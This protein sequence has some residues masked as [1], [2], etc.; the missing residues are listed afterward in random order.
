MQALIKENS[1]EA[2]KYAISAIAKASVY[3]KLYLEDLIYQCSGLSLL[4]AVAILKK[5]KDQLVQST[6]LNILSS[7]KTLVKSQLVYSLANSPNLLVREAA[8]A[9]HANNPQKNSQSVL[10]KA[11]NDENSDIKKEACRGLR[12][13]PSR[14]SAR[15]VSALLDDKDWYVRVEAAQSLKKMNKEGV[16]FLKNAKKSKDKLKKQLASYVLGNCI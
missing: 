3:Q 12:S 14:T 1:A 13:F 6:C 10:L 7:Q 5:S 2:L 9:F 4:P 8:I 15:S 16:I 11:L